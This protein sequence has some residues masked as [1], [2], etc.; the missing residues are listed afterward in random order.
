MYAA[1]SGM[2][3]NG[4]ALSVIG[5]NIANMNTTGFK[6]SRINFSDVLASSMGGVS[7]VNMQVGRGSMVSNIN[8]LFTQG[9]FI[10]TGNPLDMAIDGNGFFIVEDS[11][12]SRYYTR[13]GNFLLNANGYLITP[14]GMKVQGY[15]ASNAAASASSGSLSASPLT[16]VRVDTSVDTVK[17]TTTANITLN[18]NSHASDISATI[19]GGAFTVDANGNGK[20][21]DPA[22]YNFSNTL[23]VYDSQ[24]GGH[25]VTAYYS[26]SMT[27]ANTWDVHYVTGT[28][29]SLIMAAESQT[30]TFNTSGQLVNDN[31]ATINFNFGP[32]V[33]SPQGIV[34]DFGRGIGEGGSGISASTQLVDSNQVLA[35]NQN[36]VPPGTLRSVN[37]DK[38]GYLQATFTNGQS[39]TIG[40]LALAKFNAPYALNKMGHNL[41]SESLASGQIIEGVPN[42]AGMGGIVSGSLEQSNVD[43]ADQFVQMIASQRAF[44]AN[45]RTVTTSDEMMQET[46]NLKR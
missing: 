5:D 1:V 3:T 8:S 2:S 28:S 9:T 35:A 14:G 7:G 32:N 43:L 13:A 21:A 26:K 39:R 29:G 17:A 37:V 22:N 25:E 19:N 46:L 15:M 24:G 4:E 44:Q 45:S 11:Q 30:L 16:N 33:V 40:Q 20:N 41:F 38:D 18:L 6:G 34:F 10:S 31:Q 42:T 27:T 23:T 12:S 36:G